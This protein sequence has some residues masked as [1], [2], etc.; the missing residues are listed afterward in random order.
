M[1]MRPVDEQDDILP[2]LHISDMP[3]D[4]EAVVL[5]IK[6][7]LNMFAGEWWEKESWGN[8]ILEM[9]KVSRLTEADAQP[10]STYLAEFVRETPGVQDVTDIAYTIENRQFSWK[11]TAM[12]EYGNVSVSY[13]V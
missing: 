10:L 6:D 4:A 5:L 3:V 9:L 13:E 11:C 8:E 12:T 7:R 1:K 2:V